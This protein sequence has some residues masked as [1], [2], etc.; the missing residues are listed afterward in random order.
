MGVATGWTY[1]SPEDPTGYRWGHFNRIDPIDL[2]AGVSGVHQFELA[3]H[4]LSKYKQ[5]LIIAEL[6]TS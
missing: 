6:N 2:A 5:S 3:L 4:S 1:E